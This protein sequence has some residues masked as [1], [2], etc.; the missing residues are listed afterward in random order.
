MSTKAI[1]EA[2]EMTEELLNGVEEFSDDRA[3]LAA[4]LAEVEAIERAARLWYAVVI[5]VESSPA[6]DAFAPFERIAI[7]ASGHK[8]KA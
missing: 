7:D 6:S 8:D 3:N 2:L 4:A 1:R 5:G